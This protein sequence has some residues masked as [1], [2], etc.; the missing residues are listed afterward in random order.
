MTAP[1]RL[2]KSGT[3]PFRTPSDTSFPHGYS[4][5]MSST[6][7]HVEIAGRRNMTRLNIFFFKSWFLVVVL[8]LSNNYCKMQTLT[9]LPV[10]LASDE[11]CNYPT[12]MAFAQLLK[13]VYSRLAKEN[14]PSC[15][16]S[17]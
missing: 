11:Q 3:E 17:Y 1:I 16:I 12:R 4:H 8:N 13:Y 2:P 10:F 6:V 5:R 14:T 7:I 15:K 9:T